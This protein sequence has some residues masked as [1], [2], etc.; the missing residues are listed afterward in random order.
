MSRNAAGETQETVVTQT[1][2]TH[3]IQNYTKITFSLRERVYPSL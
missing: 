2:L 3:T 1:G